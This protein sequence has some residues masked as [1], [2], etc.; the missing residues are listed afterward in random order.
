MIVKRRSNYYDDLHVL[1]WLLMIKRESQLC[2]EACHLVLLWGA[3]A[4]ERMMMS[5]NV[6]RQVDS[7]HLTFSC[8]NNYRMATYFDVRRS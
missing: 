4:T 3:S 5:S 7:F 2:L 8:G 1:K 6:V